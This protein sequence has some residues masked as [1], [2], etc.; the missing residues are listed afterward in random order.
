MGILERME[1]ATS[2]S[3]SLNARHD[4]GRTILG[5][6]AT[7]TWLA[8]A[9]CGGGLWMGPSSG[10][11]RVV[12]ADRVGP[13][14]TQVSGAWPASCMGSISGSGAVEANFVEGGKGAGGAI[15]SAFLPGTAPP[16]SSTGL[17]IDRWEGAGVFVTPKKTEGWRV[18]PSDCTTFEASAWLDADKQGEDRHLHIRVR[19]DCTAER[20][21]RITGSLSSDDC[22]VKTWH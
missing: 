1:R 22:F 6:V 8:A 10:T 16:L 15:V 9:G 3:A 2:L 19:L 18:I 21:V 17:P 7:W 14:D 13:F 5:L 20:N 11:V 12:G 4:V